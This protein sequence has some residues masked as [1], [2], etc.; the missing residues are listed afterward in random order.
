MILYTRRLEIRPF[1]RDDWRG[2]K[3]IV[4]DFQAS[5]YRY[6]DSA[7]PTEDE[8]LRAMTEFFE[9]AGLCYAVFEQGGAEMLGYVGFHFENGSL[10]IGYRFHSSAHGK[11]Y[12]FES[13]SALMS[14]FEDTGMVERFTAGT[15]LENAPSVKLLGRLGF[16][17]T[18]TEEVCFYDG[19]PFAGGTFEKKVDITGKRPQP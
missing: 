3:R 7:M 6:F 1:R 9:N 13:I 10:E 15:A 4:L 17:Q 2:L 16:V 5:Q 18:G 12:A 14:L 19:H 11:G 8:R